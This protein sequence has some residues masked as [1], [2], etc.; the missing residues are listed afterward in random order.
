VYSTKLSA[1]HLHKSIHFTRTG[2]VLKINRTMTALSAEK[3]KSFAE[4]AAVGTSITISS[5]PI[6]VPQVHVEQS[7]PILDINNGKLSFSLSDGISN[8]GESISSNATASTDGNST[9][10]ASTYTS[11]PSRK[12]FKA[13]S[14]PASLSQ[15]AAVSTAAPEKNPWKMNLVKKEP[16]ASE[17]P[18]NAP[19]PAESKDMNPIIAVVSSDTRVNAGTSN[20]KKPT[21]S[22]QHKNK[23]IKNKKQTKRKNKSQKKNQANA[24]GGS[25]Y[26]PTPQ[27][28]ADFKKSAVEQVEYFF[29]TD[30]LVRNLYLR[31]QMDV[32][33]YLPAAIVFNFPPVL[34][35]GIPYQEL[36]NALKDSKYVDVDFENECLRVKGGE[37]EYKKWLFPNG[38]GTFGCAKWIKEPMEYTPVS[39]AKVDPDVGNEEEKED[40]ANAATDAS[41]RVTLRRRKE[42][43]DERKNTIAE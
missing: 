15:T 8:S 28:L 43:N 6:P 17:R 3:K 23:A 19:T 24:K 41:T 13:A 37:E 11:T 33:G 30:E 40:D 9:S 31:K 25:N 39:E 26:I 4:M 5:M 2:N 32:E 12:G 34:M 22:G 21:R 7:K 38:D 14:V 29:S 16:A 27:E 36:L 10:S 42:V 18:K 1:K 35:Y 20:N